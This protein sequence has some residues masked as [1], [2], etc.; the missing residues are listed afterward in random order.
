ML[1]QTRVIRTRDQYFMNLV[2]CGND[3]SYSKEIV[4][5]TGIENTFDYLVKRFGYKTMHPSSYV[6]DAYMAELLDDL[7]EKNMSF[8]KKDV[9]KTIRSSYAYR[10]GKFLVKPFSWIK[11]KTNS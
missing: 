10:L 8:V 6:Q 3:S 7:F 9:E 4:G 1:P 5:D 11:S 2:P